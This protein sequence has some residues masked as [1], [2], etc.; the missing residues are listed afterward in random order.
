MVDGWKARPICARG[1]IQLS[2]RSLSISLST[3][4]SFCLSVCL[5]CLSLSLSPPYNPRYIFSNDWIEKLKNNNLTLKKQT[6]RTWYTDAG[7]RAGVCWFEC[8]WGLEKRNRVDSKITRIST[9]GC[10]VD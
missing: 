7:R 3:C 6:H 2:P 10:S 4:F 5:L 9:K 1:V 8:K